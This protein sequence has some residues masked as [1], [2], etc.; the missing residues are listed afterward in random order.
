M[1]KNIIVSILILFASFQSCCTLLFDHI[2]N[3]LYKKSNNES[4]ISQNDSTEFITETTINDSTDTSQSIYTTL[5]TIAGVGV[6][7]SLIF[8]GVLLTNPIQINLEGGF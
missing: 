4:Y 2:G 3:N 8:I 6:D 5:F 7:L 1:F